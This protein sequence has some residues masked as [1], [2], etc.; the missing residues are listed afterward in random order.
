[1]AGAKEKKI[2][3]P[4]E[5]IVAYE[6]KK[7]AKKQR[8]KNIIIWSCVSVVFLFL[9]LGVSSAILFPKIP[10]NKV[11]KGSTI[12]QEQIVAGQPAKWVTLIPKSQII[13]GKFLAQLPR[14]AQ[15]IRL[16]TVSAEQAKNIST[17]KTAQQLSL[18][19]KQQLSATPLKISKNVFVKG[20]S[21]ALASI[22]G[23]FK[24]MFA[25]LGDAVAN[26]A[27]VADVV[28]SIVDGSA[29][30]GTIS[31]LDATYVNLSDGSQTT[32]PVTSEVAQTQDSPVTPDVPTTSIETPSSTEA[33][34]QRN[35]DA[36]TPEVSPTLPAEPLSDYIAVEYD[37]PAPQIVSETTNTGQQVTVSATN[38]DPQAP[39]TDILAST[40]IP[41]IFKVGQE[42]KIKIKWENQG[43]QEVVFS[44]YDTNSDGYLDYVEWT[45]PH[46]S[47][48]I[49][50]IIFISK[51]FQ[52]D[53]DQSI[54][55]DIYDTVKTQDNNYTTITNGQ[56]V[57]VTFDS[58]LNNK[59]DNT[60]YARATNLNSP[61]KIEVYPV[62]T[63]ADGNTTEGSIVATFDS[64]TTANTYKVFL[65]NLQ[66]PTDKFDLKV[67]GSV[68]FD[69]I[70]DPI[71]YWVGGNN[72]GDWNTD[73]NWQD[74]AVPPD[75]SDI[76]IPDTGNM[77]DP[78][79]NFSGSMNMG[80]VTM[81]SGSAIM[82]FNNSFSINGGTFNGGYYISNGG[83]ITGGTFNGPV[84]NSGNGGTITGGNFT[85]LVLNSG[86]IT[87]GTFAGTVTNYGTIDYTDGTPPD[88]TGAT[89][90]NSGTIICPDNGT[91]DP[92]AK[93]CPAAAPTFHWVG[94][95]SDNW[96]DSQNWAEGGT[97]GLPPEGASIMID[98]NS[99]NS[100]VIPY[101]YTNKNDNFGGVVLDNVTINNTSGYGIVNNGTI[102]DITG[103]FTISTSGAGI[104]NYGTITNISGVVNDNN[105][106]G[107]SG[108]ENNGGIITDISG[109]FN[110]NGAGFGIN[111][112]GT[113]ANISG[114]LTNTGG[115]IGIDNYGVIQY[116]MYPVSVLNE[117]GA[118]IYGG[119]YTSTVD[120]YGTIDAIGTSYGPPDMLGATVT[121]YSGGYLCP[122]GKSWNTNQCTV[123]SCD[124]GQYFDGSQCSQLL[125]NGAS[126]TTSIQCATNAYDGGLG[127]EC[128]T[129]CGGVGASCPGGYNSG[130]YCANNNCSAYR[131]PGAPYNTCGG[132]GATCN[133]STECEGFLA[134]VNSVCMPSSFTWTGQGNGTY[135]DDQLNWD[136]HI[137]PP[138]GSTVHLGNA[139]VTVPYGYNFGSGAWQIDGN[140]SLSFQGTNV[141]GGTFNVPVVLNSGAMISGGY[142]YSPV[143]LSMGEIHAGNFYS[144][145]TVDANYNYI[146][147]G[148]YQSSV[149][150]YGTIDM[151]GVSYGPPSFS[152]SF[153]NNGTVICGSGKYWNGGFCQALISDGDSCNLN[154]TCISGQ[155][156]PYGYCT[157]GNAGQDCWANNGCN[158]Q[159]SC[160]INGVCG[161][162][163]AYCLYYSDCDGNNYPYCVSNAC[164]ESKGVAGSGCGDPS[165]CV[166]G[167]C[168][169][170]YC[171]LPSFDAQGGSI[172]VDS[173]GT[174]VSSGTYNLTQSLTASSGNCITVDTGV[175]GVIIDG[176]NTYS[177]ENSG[178]T[179]GESGIY[180]SYG[181]EA[182]IQNITIDSTGAGSMGVYVAPGAAI[183]NIS[184]TI[185]NTYFSGL[186]NEG[187]I[188][189]IS[190]TMTNGGGTGITNY[191]TITD[192]SGIITNNSG[193]EG[194]RNENNA[195]IDNISGVVDNNSWGSGIVNGYLSSINSISGTVNN[196]SSGYGIYNGSDAYTASITI[197][198]PATITNIDGGIGFYIAGGTVNGSGTLNG[199]V[200]VESNATLDLSG[201]LIINGIV[202]NNGGTITCPSGQTWDTNQCTSPTLMGNGGYCISDSQCLSNWCSTINKCTNGAEGAEC[203]SINDCDGQLQCIDGVCSNHVT[204][205]VD[206]VC[207]SA[208]GQS[209]STI[210]TENLC[211]Q[212]SPTT[213]SGIGPWSWGCTSPNGGTDASC[214]TVTNGTNGGGED[215]QVP[216]NG[217]CG[218]SD[219][220]SFV[221]A[222]T[223]G[224]CITGTPTTVSGTGPWAW[225]CAGSNGGD[226]VNCSA[227][228]IITPPAVTCGDGICNGNESCGTCPSDC[229]N[230]GGGPVPPGGTTIVSVI[231]KNPIIQQLQ[232]IPEAVVKQISNV[233]KEISNFVSNKKEV[234]IPKTTPLALQGL[235]FM[236]VN[237]LAGFELTPIAS[238]IRF[239]SNK[240]PQLKK[241]L[242]SLSIDIKK[243]ADISKLAQTELYLPGLTKTLFTPS[244]ILQLSPLAQNQAIPVEQLTPAKLAK[245]P[246]N[247]VF[248]SASQGLIDFVSALSIDKQGGASQVVSTVSGIQMQLVIK[249]EQP[250]SRVTQII[251]LKSPQSAQVLKNSSF[252]AGYFGAALSASNAVATSENVPTDGVL[253]QK[254]DYQEVKPGLFKVEFNAPVVSGQYDVITIIEYKDQKTVPTTTHL[255][256]VVDPEGYIYQNISGMQARVPNATVSIYQLNIS[257]NKYELWPA[258][259]FLQKNPIVTDETGKYSFLVPQGTYYLTIDTPNYYQYKS[260]SFVVQSGNGIHMDVEL[261]KKSILPAWFSWNL[262]IMIVFLVIVILLSVMVVLIIVK[263]GR[264]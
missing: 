208:D 57:R 220:V 68:D 43:N 157:S 100:P 144:T 33:T 34:S 81:D 14:G 169:D 140:G 167:S 154:E 126:C 200:T 91:W 63:D 120:N 113:I 171:S 96:T 183:T 60:I 192:I 143:E 184:A 137:V 170:G 228:A 196:N 197:N 201:G 249:P 32:A 158:G 36:P 25:D 5:L 149:Y 103:T 123:S 168:V 55:A 133:T 48:Q 101:G 50:N 18:V 76:Y 99:L 117:V 128:Q 80:T 166:S 89:V 202:S 88:L 232:N 247:V 198:G 182:T 151:T 259:K 70:V 261:Q 176:R 211:L 82:I 212:G 23:A 205:L 105:S 219:G 73:A 54:L 20:C 138:D 8:K 22:G 75:G 193:Y 163:S 71:Y 65:T 243:P 231:S 263:K 10:A 13:S 129:I 72:G 234:A 86:T 66:T 62:Y 226:T 252:S 78:V 127:G 190:G 38:E 112:M 12:K 244:E 173:C 6:G 239:F 37:T 223:G 222:P 7:L 238:D 39:L 180:I 191:G 250:A 229:V 187:I 114:A 207:G 124:Y 29:G 1:M 4:P 210:P 216:I 85:F 160:G 93:Q 15:N 109:T 237:P 111:N 92:N 69:Y 64:I 30:Q 11:V 102:T 215:V 194:I 258:E 242:E 142:F 77:A 225:S 49:F 206:G 241:A 156:S 186:W 16:T 17:R 199:D 147:G 246:S 42:D 61:A 56:S 161:G 230:C 2:V 217:V 135:W 122:S 108:I 221:L 213:V 256:M 31:T 26:I 116:G 67:T 236:S 136:N 119:T 145:V 152:S 240:I 159:F 9:V 107:A 21:T 97:L 185:N 181:A 52:L 264:K 94:G 214:N 53:T 125:N 106:D 204:G 262:K 253:I 132:M 131:D 139:Y 121:D 235:D 84:G 134:C 35:S 254:S 162:D 83:T 164:S 59:N 130:M 218:L 251:T 46:L 257:T 203:G 188:G 189:D 51:A 118:Y 148:L 175:T 47:E 58:P 44:A 3:F 174:I 224:L 87:G 104:L 19:Q 41:K 260:S 141:S 24:Y 45:V 153:S 178:S 209:P 255:T 245:I 227:T 28:Q 95:N 195:I 172:N 150:N 179:P 155:C 74:G 248:A 79:I 115:G 110:N 40:K 165:D 233:A 98:S 146:Y 90:N 177:I 27:P